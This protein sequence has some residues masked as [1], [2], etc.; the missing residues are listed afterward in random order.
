MAPSLGA[1]LF[2]RSRFLITWMLVLIGCLLLLAPLSAQERV[3]NQTIDVK[4]LPN[5]DAQVQE[6]LR[7]AAQ[8]DLFR[9]GLVR[10]LVHH[11]ATLGTSVS[12]GQILRDQRAEPYQLTRRPD[13]VVLSTGDAS[14]RLETGYHDFS[15]AYR[16]HN[17]VK[18]RND[19][20]ELGWR[21]VSEQQAYAIDRLQVRVVL[22]DEKQAL[23]AQLQ[24]AGQTPL[25]PVQSEPGRVV[26]ELDRLPSHTALMLQLNWVGSAIAP[27]GPLLR[28]W[29]GFVSQPVWW[30]L[31]V[32]G[33]LLLLYW[34]G[35]LLAQGWSVWRSGAGMVTRPPDGLPVSAVRYLWKRKVDPLVLVLT[36]QELIAQRV[37]RM[38]SKPD[39]E[40]LLLA[41]PPGEFDKLPTA[42]AM[43]LE[44]LFESGREVVRLDGLFKHCV[45]E[46]YAKLSNWLK[47]AYGDHYLLDRSTPA[48]AGLGAWLIW[49]ALLVAVGTLVSGAPLSWETWK[50][51]L[52]VPAACMAWFGF[53]RWNLRKKL[54]LN[55]ALLILGAGAWAAGSLYVLQR[56]GLSLD[57]LV[58]VP[59]LLLLLGL[60]CLL[61][62]Q[63]GYNRAGRR[64]MGELR[65]FRRYLSE[66]GLQM[67]FVQM[68]PTQRTAEFETLLPYAAALDVQSGWRRHFNYHERTALAGHYGRYG[69]ADD[70]EAWLGLLIEKMA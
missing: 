34:V 45:A 23:G 61:F 12:M 1:S 35:L 6:S 69:L 3:A 25:E 67:G 40:F 5:G 10:P 70:Y 62:V 24:V 58:Y 53:R 27:P 20:L 16:L 46:V 37:V 19:Q 31:T 36:L 42:S 32:G 4:V 2:T 13:G 26:F 55:H 65:R 18:I 15:L 44:R 29:Q 39:G 41:Q 11:G 57:A 47:N 68:S 17:L 48:V 33:L 50:P 56:Q 14:R 43:L 59:A 63:S 9:H 49:L 7:I 30:V 54:S 52:W 8:G 38:E 21:V 66:P 22:P 28:L 60:E 64:L 51:L